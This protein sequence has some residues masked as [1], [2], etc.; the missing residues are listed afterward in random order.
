MVA[1]GLGLGLA[2]G[3]RP[4]GE[5][6]VGRRA[7]GRMPVGQKLCVAVLCECFAF[8]AHKVFPADD[9]ENFVCLFLCH[10]IVD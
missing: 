6:L 3:R 8:R 2:G 5:G 4:A 9:G 7:A 1:V 10:L